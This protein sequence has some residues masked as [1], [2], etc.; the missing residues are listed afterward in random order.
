MVNVRL[1]KHIYMQNSVYELTRDDIKKL[2]EEFTPIGV[3]QA[4]VD[5]GWDIKD[6]IRLNKRFVIKDGEFKARI[7]GG[8]KMAYLSEQAI[9]DFKEKGISFKVLDRRIKDG[10]DLLKDKLE[11]ETV[12]WKALKIEREDKEREE[13]KIRE[14]KEKAE[15]Q[16]KARLDMI[17]KARCNS[18]WFRDLETN[19]KMAR[20][21]KDIYG[22]TQLI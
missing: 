5:A 6:A 11:N 14:K 21:K 3:V 17:K 12:D 2:K 4:R 8:S 22:N 16:E 20:L 9:E 13:R 10:T 15:Q 19:N 1:D 7:C 18:R